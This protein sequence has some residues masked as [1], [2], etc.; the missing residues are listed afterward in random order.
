MPWNFTEYADFKVGGA[1]VT[2]MFYTQQHSAQQRTQFVMS[3]AH[4]LAG[5]RYNRASFVKR[6]HGV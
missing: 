2:F 3:V 5:R 4:V 6:M 1:I